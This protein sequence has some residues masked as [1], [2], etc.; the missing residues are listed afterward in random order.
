MS[1][2]IERVA[3]AAG[4]TLIKATKNTFVI[5]E[6]TGPVVTE[7]SHHALGAGRVTVKVLGKVFSTI[8]GGK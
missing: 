8:L 4:E 1:K 7:I 2:E 5:V 3:H 6:K